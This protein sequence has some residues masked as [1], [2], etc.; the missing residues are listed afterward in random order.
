MGFSG[1]LSN[2][3]TSSNKLYFY[4]YEFS[5]ISIHILCCFWQ[6]TFHLSIFLNEHLDDFIKLHAFRFHT[7][8]HSGL[9]PVYIEPFSARLM[10]VTGKFR[11]PIGRLTQ[12]TNS[13]SEFSSHSYESR[14][15]K[16]QYKRTS[17]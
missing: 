14:A 2:S 6:V 3:F 8:K 13:Q 11:S 15:E 7:W 17:R 9:R 12:S 16:A 4:Q 10:T 5:K 1:N